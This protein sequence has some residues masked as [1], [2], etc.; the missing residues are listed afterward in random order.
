MYKLISKMNFSSNKQLANKALNQKVIK[1]E[2]F[3]DCFQIIVKA[4]AYYINPSPTYFAELQR[5]FLDLV[6]HTTLISVNSQTFGM[7]F[8]IQRK[9]IGPSKK[10]PYGKE[11]KKNLV[12][13]VPS[14]IILISGLYTIV[15]AYQAYELTNL[16]EP[17]I[18]VAHSPHSIYVNHLNSYLPFFYQLYFAGIIVEL[19]VVLRN[20]SDLQKKGEYKGLKN[21]IKQTLWQKDST[22]KILIY[23]N[24][25]AICSTLIPIICQLIDV[26]AA[27]PLTEIYGSLIIG[28]IQCRIGYHLITTNI[29]FIQGALSIDQKDQDRIKQLIKENDHIQEVT[30]LYAVYMGD[31]SFRVAADITFKFKAFQD[32]IE[33]KTVQLRQSIMYSKSPEQKTILLKQFMEE[34]QEEVTANMYLEEFPAC[35]YV[36]FNL[37]QHE[38][39]QQNQAEKPNQVF[40]QTETAPD[41]DFD[42][43]FKQLVKET[44]NK[45]KQ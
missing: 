11:K 36:D 29:N 23:E 4:S 43:W 17:L 30:D 37:N 34:I 45:I 3:N 28:F 41:I 33:A 39:T 10:F 31:Q 9:I 35:L 38:L 6:N 32:I 5:Q 1:R 27:S 19:F 15:K 22:R 2:I 14:S 20:I 18:E 26:F 12:L 40:W 24:M 16:L 44:I 21:L 42:D 25:I 7:Y 13:V 8:V